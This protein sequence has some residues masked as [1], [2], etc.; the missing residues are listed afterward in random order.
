M[1]RF[2]FKAVD[3]DRPRLFGWN[4][5]QQIRG[6]TYL[7]QGPRGP[8]DIRVLEEGAKIVLEGPEIGYVS[9]WWMCCAQRSPCYHSG[10]FR[11]AP[12][13]GGSRT[14]IPTMRM[15]TPTPP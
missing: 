14:V 11:F 13:M 7:Y 15:A 3:V 2:V 5:P 1:E 8:V 6:R 12:P 4:N 9:Q 10:G